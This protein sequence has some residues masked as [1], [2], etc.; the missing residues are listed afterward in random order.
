MPNNCCYIKPPCSPLLCVTFLQSSNLKRYHSKLMKTLQNVRFFH[1]WIFPWRQ[2]SFILTPFW[3]AK[4]ALLSSYW[5]LFEVQLS[6][7]WN[8]LSQL[9]DNK[10]LMLTLKMLV[11]S[12]FLRLFI[13]WFVIIF[14]ISVFKVLS[15]KLQ[16]ILSQNSQIN[17]KNRAF[18]AC[19]NAQ[20]P[21]GHR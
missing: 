14:Q 16:C 6:T 5:R 7:F 20:R 3:L 18:F 19:W 1:K 8:W 11:C 2:I 15:L 13:G 9:F 21:K 4:D 12:S 17:R 10:L